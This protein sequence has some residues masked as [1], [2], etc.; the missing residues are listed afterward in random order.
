MTLNRSSPSDT[1]APLACARMLAAAMRISSA[2]SS[3]RG[4]GCVGVDFAP[5]TSASFAGDAAWQR[6][7]RLRPPTATAVLLTAPA[8]RGLGAAADDGA[9][10]REPPTR[11][12]GYPPRQPEGLIV[13]EPSAA[14]AGAVPAAEAVLRSAYI[15][16]SSV[17]A[18]IARWDAR[19]CGGIDCGRGG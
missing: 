6:P 18:A 11:R 4:W 8:A 5:A 14:P 9:V 3:S 1:P 7:A 12:D 15:L 19:V 16:F 13:W 17:D 2:V 10:W